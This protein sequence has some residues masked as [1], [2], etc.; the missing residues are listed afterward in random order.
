MKRKKQWKLSSQKAS[1][2][3]NAESDKQ[4]LFA[5]LDRVSGDNH[6]EYYRN[7]TE[8]VKGVEKKK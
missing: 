2:A 5:F 7:I 4:R 3:A 6:T 8:M 1:K